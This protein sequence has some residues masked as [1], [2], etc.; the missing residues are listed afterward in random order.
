MTPARPSLHRVGADAQLLH[1]A[2]ADLE[3]IRRRHVGHRAAGGQVGQHDLLVRRA[4]NVGALGHEVHAAEHDVVGLRA[5][6]GRARELQRIADVVGELDDLV[7]L[8]VMAEDDAPLAERRLG[9]GDARVELVVRQTEISLR[10]RL[11]LADALLLEVGQYLNVHVRLPAWLPP[12]G[13]RRRLPRKF[14]R[15]PQPSG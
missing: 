6:G 1:L 3:L 4:K 9:A 14:G 2:P 13:G 15:L 11:A 8:V 7:A 5:R 10:E 12:S